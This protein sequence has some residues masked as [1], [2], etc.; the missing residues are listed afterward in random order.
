M[1]K[2]KKFIEKRLPA[3]IKIIAMSELPVIG[4]VDDPDGFLDDV[5]ENGDNIIRHITAYTNVPV[6]YKTINKINENIAYLGCDV[7]F[8]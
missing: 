3:G 4:K 8:K 1:K 7:E 2:A 6:D 5:K